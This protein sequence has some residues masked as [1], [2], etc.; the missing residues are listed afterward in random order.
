MEYAHTRRGDVLEVKLVDQTRKIVYRVKVN[1]NDKKA[2]ANVFNTL[3]SYGLDLLEVLA[4]A[5][6]K[7]DNWF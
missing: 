4:I 2:V 7:Q 5:R 3:E 6:S 1:I